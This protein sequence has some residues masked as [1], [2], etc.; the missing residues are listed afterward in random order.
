MKDPI[1]E[2]I[3]SIREKILSECDGDIEKLMNRLKDSETRDK[4]RIVSPIS[5][6]EKVSIK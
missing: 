4:K 6:K 2:E 1:V 3:H 5:Q